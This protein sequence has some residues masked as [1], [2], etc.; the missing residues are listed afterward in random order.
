MF[1]VA[2]HQGYDKKKSNKES[3]KKNRTNAGCISKYTSPLQRIFLYFTGYR[4]PDN[5]R[6]IFDLADFSDPEL[7]RSHILKTR[8]NLAHGVLYGGSI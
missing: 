6:K 4:Q 2:T 1:L 7:K 3:G 8:Q 5:R